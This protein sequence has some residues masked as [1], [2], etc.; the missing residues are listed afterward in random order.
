[1]CAFDALS[2]VSCYA[3]AFQ[4]IVVFLWLLTAFSDWNDSATANTEKNELS[5]NWQFIETYRNVGVWRCCISPIM[6][7]DYGPSFCS[8]ISSK[9]LRT[10]SQLYYHSLSFISF[11]SDSA[12]LV[13]I[14]RYCGSLWLFDVIGDCRF[15][16]NFSCLWKTGLLREGIVKFVEITDLTHHSRVRPLHSDWIWCILSRYQLIS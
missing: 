4:S 5:V 3:L 12:F 6:D 8:N 15:L 1:M 16:R 10:I 2:H 11:C 9:R 7:R 14:F 13:E